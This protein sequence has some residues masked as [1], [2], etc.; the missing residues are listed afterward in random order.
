LQKRK[1]GNTGLQLSII[2]FG[3][4]HLVEVPGKESSFLLNTYLDRGGNYIETAAQYGEGI[5]EKK[6][7]RALSGRRDD[8]ILATKTKARTRQ[9]ALQSLENSLKNLKTDHVDIF[10]MHEPQ[11]IDES[12]QILA[13]GGAMEAVHVIREAGKASWVGISGHG[14]PSGLIHAVEHYPYD[15]LMTGFNYFD[16][17]NF[18]QIEEELLP[19]CSKKETAVLGMKALADGYLYRNPIDAIRYAL[20]QPIVSLVLGM[21]SRTYLEQDL[22]IAEQFTPMT[23]QE[24]TALYTS[25]V[26]LGSYVC[27]RCG[28][29]RD[30]AGINP[31]EIFLIEGLFDRQMDSLEEVHPPHYALQERLKH[32][33]GQTAWARKEY[34]LLE[35][36]VD[37]SA[38]YSPLNARCPYGINVDRKL[39]IVHAKLYPDR[40]VY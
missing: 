7:G 11:T 28:K 18:P 16:H 17:F 33:F 39:K 24:V 2:G 20:S 37:P 4:F 6:I 9:G 12:K 14:R 38:D 35:N 26:E 1:L 34:E 32:W 25:A 29:C 36:K 30:G 31:Q 21:N 10:F 3:G 5:S 15:V 19:L 22:E 40:Y 27:R 13:P 8:F 23:E